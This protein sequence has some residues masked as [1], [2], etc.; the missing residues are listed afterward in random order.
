MICKTSSRTRKDFTPG[1]RGR[2]FIH[3]SDDCG[4][5]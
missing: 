4:L 2:R 1:Y 5:D 3:D